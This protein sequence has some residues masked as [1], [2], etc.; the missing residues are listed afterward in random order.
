MFVRHDNVNSRCTVTGKSGKIFKV[1]RYRKM[2]LIIGDGV[3]PSFFEPN[4]S[5]IVMKW[6]TYKSDGFP[7]PSFRYGEQLSLQIFD[8]DRFLL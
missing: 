1:F 2:R 6:P 3:K 5:E 8:I 7:P 4:Y